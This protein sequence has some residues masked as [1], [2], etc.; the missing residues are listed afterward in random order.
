MWE[1]MNAFTKIEVFAQNLNKHTI[2]LD[3]NISP[4]LNDL[5]DNYDK[6]HVK[7]K[8]SKTE[9]K[10]FLNSICLPSNFSLEESNSMSSNLVKYFLSFLSK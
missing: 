1:I 8:S 4:E 7:S 2:V 5:Y 10:R 6:I 9:I 3:P